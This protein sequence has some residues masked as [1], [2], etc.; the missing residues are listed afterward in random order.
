MRA[1]RWLFRF[2]IFFLILS[3]SLRNTQAVV[4]EV[5]PGYALKA[6]LIIVLLLTFIGAVALTWLIMLP[7]ILRLRRL[8]AEKSELSSSTSNSKITDHGI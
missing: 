1:L 7:A 2:L 4:V 3:F 6:P 5:L 8:E